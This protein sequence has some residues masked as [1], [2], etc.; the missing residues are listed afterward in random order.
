MKRVV[1]AMSG[2]VDSSVTA[3][4]L[5]TRGYDVVG[6]MMQVWPEYEEDR[7]TGGCCSLSAAEDARRV[8]DRLGVP[9]Y[10]VNFQQIFQEQV[11]DYFVQ[12]YSLGR[13]PNP[14][15]M[16]N[17]AI[18]F[19]ALLQRALE[20]DADYLATGHYAKII[21]NQDGRHLLYKGID[22]SKDQTY[23]LWGLDQN[24]LAHTLF[25]LGELTKEETRKL[26]K[27]YNL[28]VAGKPDSQEI[29]FIP[30]D[31]YGRFLKEHHPRLVKPGP[32]VDTQ[33]NQLGTHEGLPFYTIG[34]RKGLGIALGKPAYV[35]DLDTKR[36]AVVIGENSD[37][38]GAGL[39][40]GQVNWI[41]VSAL[42][43]P[44]EVEAQI[45]YNSQAAK[46]VV[47]PHENG[48]IKVIFESMQRAITPGQSVVF[49]HG[50]LLVGGAIIRKAIKEIPED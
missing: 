42:T 12:E 40:A 3:A 13:T 18:K 31:D 37:V 34:Q 2:G 8:A 45:R 28:L 14:C 10:L 5:K 1:V 6:M 16:C 24:Q 49:Y 44:L 4:L 35:V 11:I 36:N 48:Q 27:E 19:Q 32:I 26:A 25:P 43:D 22:R 41:S 23:T 7:D 33:G 20:L 30:D 47:Y 38:Y 9:F 39:I 29:C 15:I 50:D 17:K 46:A 21:H